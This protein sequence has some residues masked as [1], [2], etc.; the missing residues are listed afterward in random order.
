VVGIIPL[1]EETSVYTYNATVNRV[2][3]GDTVVLTVDL[4]FR[5]STTI[6][7]RLLGI[8]T[9]ELVGSERAD[10]LS[11]KTALEQILATAASGIVLIRSELPLKTDKYGRWLATIW[12]DPGDGLLVNVNEEMVNLG[13]ATAAS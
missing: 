1:V 5:I 13:L 4:G 2:V 10:G 6:T 9:P 7:F 12:L 3:D 8:D 11:A